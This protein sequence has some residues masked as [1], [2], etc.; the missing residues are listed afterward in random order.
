MSES[1]LNRVAAIIAENRKMSIDEIKLESTFSELN[2]DS[3]AALSLVFDFEEAFNVSIPNE[4]VV[5]MQN[6]RDVVE[7]LE[8]LG[9]AV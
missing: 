9:V 3:L 8:R 2:I 5:T 7:S 4:E 1:V 6:V